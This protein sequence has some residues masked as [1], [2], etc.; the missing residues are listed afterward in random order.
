MTARTRLTDED[1]RLRIRN[2]TITTLFVEAGA[3]SGKTHVLVSRAQTLAVE[4]GIPIGKIAAVTFTERAASEL[5]D[6]LRARLEQAAVHTTRALQRERALAALDDLDTAAIGTLHSFAQ[7]ILS[8]HPIEAGIPPLIE[9]LDEVGSSVAFEGRWSELR[10]ELLDDPSMS[11]TV[12]MALATGI[13]L[14]HVRSLITK[15]NSDWDLVDEHIIAPGRPPEPTV[16]DVSAFLTQARRLSAMNTLCTDSEDKFLP[17]LLALGSWADELDS[18]RDDV[19]ARLEVLRSVSALRW[20]NGQRVNWGDH[21]GSQDRLGHLR[22][23]CQGLQQGVADLVLEVVGATLRSIVH[24]CGVRVLQSAGARRAEGRLEFH[25]LLVLARNLLRESADVRADLQQRY[26]RLLLDEFQD[27]DPIQIEIAVRI[28]GGAAATQAHWEDVHVPPGSLFVVGDPKQSIYRFR[29]ADISMYLR[30]QQMLRGEVSLTTNF[31]T[32]A[33]ILEWV[34]AVFSRVIVADPEKQ[35]QYQP[36]TAFR[37]GPTIGAPVTVLGAGEHAERLSAGQLREREAAD[38]ARSIVQA[39]GEGWT[40]EVTA[41]PSAPDAGTGT[42]T[43][44]RTGTGTD[45]PLTQP[46]WRPLRP[47][48]ITILLPARTSLPFL[49]TALDDAGV[50]YRTESSSLVYHAQEVRDLFAAVRALADPSDAFALVTALRSP[51]FGCGD[52]DLWTWKQ[53]RGS[54]RLLA[55]APKGHHDHP[56]AVAIASLNDLY[57]RSRWLTP[58]EVL[59]AIAVDRRM[60][61]AA[62]AGPRAR[63]SWRRLRFVID[64]ARAWSEVE[65]GGLR[66]YLGWATAQSAEGSRVA[67]SVLPESDVDSVRIMTIHAAKGLEFPMVV[68]SGMTAQPRHE[69]GVRLLWSPDGYAVSLSRDLQ[70]GDFQ[71]QVPLDE[72]MS[73]YER[74]RL[75]YVAA[76]RARDHLVVSLHRSSTKDTN[77][78]RLADADAAQAGA[79]P[80]P[81]G[82]AG[83]APT[84][85]ASVVSPPPD[86][87]TWLARVGQSA[88]AS[89]QHPAF[90][91]S[92][93]EGTDPDAEGPLPDVEGPV[94]DIA[95]A[96]DIA[97]ISTRTDDE[98]A[99]GVAKGGRDVELPAWSKGR[100]GSAIGRAVH[101]VLQVV[102]LTSG[103][104]VE[105]AVAAQCVAEGVVELAPLVTLLVRSALDSDVVKRA[106]TREHWRESYV[107]MVQPDGSV[108]EGFVD[109]IYREDDGWLVIVDYKTDDAPDGALPSRA[110][111]YAPQVDAYRSILETA[112][113]RPAAAP[114]LLF[115]RR[116]AARSVTVNGHPR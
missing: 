28:A 2:D 43:G 111:Y 116:T 4:D 68:L 112:V 82:A 114:I 27:T 64:Q 104:G 81:A 13:T 85:P 83:P 52:D 86:L 53:A 54:F 100:Y 58:S 101:G 91:A 5:R 35:P 41:P 33:P 74:L 15:L 108:L 113:E 32:G 6:R 31:R 99:S 19:A 22:A 92:G 47:G 3:G 37:G 34:N 102:D 80:M 73:S 93:L 78:Q 12:E 77:A 38:V 42:R 49:E 24:W 69:R 30:A 107:G 98:V 8:E 51:L 62:A 45:Q 57:R 105:D 16:P 66:S 23:Q 36:L 75:M 14:D 106:S 40:T 10:T 55:P 9:V 88:R 90:S 44:T 29:R 21:Q 76:T 71:D 94:P 110:G 115:A 39:L 103:D 65:H 89:R 11:A 96:A 95:V 97:I 84:Q 25:D 63:D 109:L 50:M 61:E 17:K 56:V 60:F 70:T 59:G 48:D 20:G 87:D 72:Q 79:V 18:A 1:A 26:Q 7:R 46:E 67:E